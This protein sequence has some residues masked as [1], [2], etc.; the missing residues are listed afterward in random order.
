L[1]VFPVS[2]D[3]GGLPEYPSAMTDNG[4]A[5]KL[6][7]RVVPAVFLAVPGSGEITPIGY[8]VMAEEE[9]A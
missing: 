4:I 6:E 2:L 8:G 7:V 5:A 3:G 1:T 9:L